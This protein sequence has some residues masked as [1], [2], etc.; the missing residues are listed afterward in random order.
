MRAGELMILQAAVSGES[1]LIRD[2]LIRDDI[3]YDDV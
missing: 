2:V 3:G 1:K